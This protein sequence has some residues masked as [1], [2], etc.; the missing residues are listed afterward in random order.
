M[1]S[2]VLPAYLLARRVVRPAAALA[3]AAL[4]VGLPSM[5]YVGTLMTENAFYPIFLWLAFALVVVLERPTARNQVVVLALC[6]LAFETRAQAIALFAAVLTAPLAL[7]WIERGRPR[8]LKAFAPL[9]G[10]VAAGAVLVAIVEAARGRSPV[11]ILGS[12][13]K[14]SNGGYHV[15]PVVR[16]LV[17]HV[18]ELDLAL[19]VL[20]FAALI[21]LVANA[22]HLDRRLRIFSAAAASLSIW[23]VLEV[24]VFA[25]QYSHR[26]EE[27]NLFYLMPLFLIALLAWIERGQPRPPRGAIAA[28]GI[29]AAL[30]GALP[31][32]NLLDI[33]AQSD[34]LGFQSWWY[35]GEAWAGRDS[36]S[37]L[38]VLVSLV[39]AAAFL[40]LPRR[41]APVLPAIVALGFLVTWLPLELWKH[42]FPQ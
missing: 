9:Y 26:V 1:S 14:T 42:G 6:V 18:A 20:P 23:L 27:R 40:W 4:A 15:W 17:L 7:A 32:I 36:V 3:A 22:R 28:A 24:A 25:S 31:F 38:A 2:A 30:P 10:I 13:S 5:A 12:Y 41:Y 16:W 39:L 37:L 29:A 11:D 35:A 33:T 8:S 21:V 19:W 34:T